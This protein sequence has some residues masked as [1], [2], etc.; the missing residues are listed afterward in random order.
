V[1]VKKNVLYNCYCYSLTDKWGVIWT[2][3]AMWGYT[4]GENLARSGGQEYCRQGKC[5]GRPLGNDVFL[6]TLEIT[7]NRRLRKKKTGPK[8]AIK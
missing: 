5:G 6:D 7:F 4:S 1:R 2:S 3:A 8:K